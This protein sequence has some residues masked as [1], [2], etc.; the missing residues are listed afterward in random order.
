MHTIHNYRPISGIIRSLILQ[1]LLLH[2]FNG[3][4]PGQPA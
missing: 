4:Y 3:L 2:P 1:V